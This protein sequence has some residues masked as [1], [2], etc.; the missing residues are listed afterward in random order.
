MKQTSLIRSHAMG[1]ILPSLLSLTLMLFAVSC[2]MV[3]TP[4]SSM[5]PKAQQ[6]TVQFKIGDS[7]ADRVFAFE[8]T[9]GPISLTPDTGAPVTILSGTQRVELSHLSATSVPLSVLS[10][11]QGSYRSASIGVANPEITFLNSAGQVQHIEPAFN[12]TITIDF[13]P[14]LAI[15]ASSVVSIDLDI[16]KALSFDAQGNPTGVNLNA[17]SFSVGSAAVAG[18][19]RQSDDDGELEDTTGTITAVNGTSFTL[20]VTQTGAVLMFTTDANTE[21][22]DGASLAVN[23]MVT[24]DGMTRMDGTLY[25]A[26]VEGSEDESGAEAEGLITA[27]AG[28]PATSLTLV[29]DEESGKGMASGVGSMVTANVSNAQFLVD[30]GDIDTAGIGGLPSAPEFPFSASTVHAGQRVQLESKESEVESSGSEDEDGGKGGSLQGDKV[31]LQQQTLVGTVSGLQS[32]A[33]AGPVTLTLTVASD[34]AFAMLSGQTQVM[35]FWQPGTDLKN[36]S[37]VSN[38]QTIRVRGLVFYTG[39]GF[40]MVARRITN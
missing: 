5:A 16:S 9:L 4:P 24:V 10:I 22:R 34:S 2:G 23:T 32:P 36:L 19:D 25:A 37:A 33:N 27:V 28:N 7:P 15:S 17:A 18:N 30:A 11:P 8:V 14:S 12:Q 20:S 21:F 40:N 38:G 3:T 13:N 26:R 6:S 39:T 35:V 1:R 31:R 29:A